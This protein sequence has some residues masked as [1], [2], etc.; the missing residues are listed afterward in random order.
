MALRKILKSTA[1]GF[2]MA[3]GSM[4][5]AQDACNF[6]GETITIIVPFG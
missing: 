5:A 2:T 3:I 4:A 6:E 1:I